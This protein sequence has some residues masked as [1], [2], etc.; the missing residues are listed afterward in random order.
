MRRTAAAL[1]SLAWPGVYFGNIPLSILTL[2]MAPLAL[3]A[4]WDAYRV[5]AVRSFYRRFE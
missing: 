2:T 3:W 5:A 1:L 4:G